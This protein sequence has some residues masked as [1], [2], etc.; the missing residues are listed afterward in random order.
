M[1]NRASI[2]HRLKEPRLFSPPFPFFY[3][4][5]LLL[6][7]SFVEGY[8]LPL[9]EALVAGTPVIASALPAF[10][11]LA[12]NIPEY[13][14]PTDTK[15]WLSVIADYTNSDSALRAA[16]LKRLADYN[17]PSWTNHFSKIDIFLQSIV[18]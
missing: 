15:Q 1:R 6:F 3:Y 9:I 12:H 7:P 5:T 2:S 13:I 10:R 14:D 8:G 16:Q 4:W 17:A 18:A 11:E